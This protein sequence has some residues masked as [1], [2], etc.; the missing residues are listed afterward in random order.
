MNDMKQFAQT[1]ITNDGEGAF[2]PAEGAEVSE[3]SYKIHVAGEPTKDFVIGMLTHKIVALIRADS[4]N[5][6]LP[7]PRI[8][9]VE[10]EVTQQA[11]TDDWPQETCAT[12]S[13]LLANK[14]GTPYNLTQ[15]SRR[16][17]DLYGFRWGTTGWAGTETD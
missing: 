9:W 13:F 8:H 10:F 15:E 17:G 1:L 12:A 2:D 14:D 11:E 3:Y 5:Q 16:T 7:S 4:K 6:N